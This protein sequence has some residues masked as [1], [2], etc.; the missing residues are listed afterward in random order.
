MPF[1]CLHVLVLLVKPDLVVLSHKGD[2]EAEKK[3]DEKNSILDPAS[4]MAL[5]ESKGGRE[6]G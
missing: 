4:H 1:H 2:I 6:L 3:K 5:S